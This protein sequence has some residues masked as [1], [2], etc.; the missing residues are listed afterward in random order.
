MIALYFF[1]KC[2]QK[3]DSGNTINFPLSL[4]YLRLNILNKVSDNMPQAFIKE[5]SK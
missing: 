1:L 4:E 2:K 5:V 3:R